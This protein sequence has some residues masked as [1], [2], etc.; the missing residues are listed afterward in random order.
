MARRFWPHGDALGKRLRLYYDKDQRWLTVIGVVGDA[1]YRY[2]EEAAPQAFLPYL[3]NPYRSLPYAK[4][5]DPSVSLVVRTTAD[6]AGMIPAVRASIWEVDKDQPIVSIEPMESI[7]WQSVAEP[8]VYTLLLGVFAAIAL[9]IA[10]AG[11]YGVAAYAVV[12]RTREIGIRLA[13]GAAPA[14]I[15][16]L[17]LRQGM[18][19]TLLGVGIGVAGSLVAREVLAGFLFGVTATD[20]PTFLVVVLLFAAVAFVSTYIPARR[21]ARI[22]PTLAFRYE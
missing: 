5:K 1:R 18:L 2:E 9:V 3:Q 15:L 14:Q 6:P 17:V 10:S 8:R 21:A 4:Q 20:A 11:I 7:L 19:L 12:R 16:T 22:D 13:V